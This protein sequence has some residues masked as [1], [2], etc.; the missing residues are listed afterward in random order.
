MVKRKK[1]SSENA[2]NAVIA[3]VVILA[4]IAVAAVVVNFDKLMPSS[5][6]DTV[7]A[8]VNG[9]K[10][11][12]SDVQK[13]L[14]YLTAQYGPVADREL[15]L[16]LSINEML[17]VQEAKRLG[18]TIDDA[19]VDKA[20]DEW[21][22]EV[23]QSMTDEDLNRILKEQNLTMEGFI[24][25]TK[26]A[27][28]KNMIVYSLV[29]QTVLSKL[30]LLA[31]MSLDVTDAEIKDFYDKHGAELEQVKVSH[32]LICYK[33]APG[34][35][36]NRTQEEALNRANDIYQQLIS[37]KSFAELAE[38]YSD[39]PSAKG[40]GG[41]LEW[42]GRGSYT[43]EFEKAAFSMRYKNQYTKPVET[44]FGYHIIKLD[45]RRS[46]FDELKDSIRLE[47]EMSK[48]LEYRTLK[49]QQE[50]KAVRDY[51]E[52][53]RQKSEI[54]IEKSAIIGEA[55]A[56]KPGI[57]TFSER[58]NEVCVDSLGRPIVRMYSTTWCP[59]CKWVSA[60]YEK[61]AREYEAAG[62]IKAYHWELDINDDTLSEF[63][64]SALPDLEKRVY[65]QF[66]PQGSVPT[67]VFGCR[68]Y[69]IGN[70]YEGE[71]DLRA[72]EAEFR[73]VIEQVLK[74]I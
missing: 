64:E 61:V 7:A 16:N 46:T 5:K 21:L 22:A 54:R 65:Q 9:E 71:Q 38:K 69:R 20:V 73:A 70:G 48:Q 26:Q 56:G 33:G 3:V 57:R 15:A 47:L 59:H 23:R 58:E 35:K 11:L 12:E 2:R 32:I 25:D 24:S 17:L 45:E 53:L 67:F 74:E 50:E 51:I 27:Y 19:A 28:R 30:P 8:Y 14:T 44:A 39:D 34:C 60:T 43:E 40:T 37:G 66:S 62:K 31:D 13:R 72:E 4:V 18:I 29:N 52:S 63:K 49:Q 41:Q 6:K 1:P 68:Y 42:A 10:I 36:Q 55:A